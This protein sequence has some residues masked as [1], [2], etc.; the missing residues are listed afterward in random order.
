MSTKDY[1]GSVYEF[2]EYAEQSVIVEVATAGF[3]TGLKK[4]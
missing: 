3:L 1:N 4:I 2:G